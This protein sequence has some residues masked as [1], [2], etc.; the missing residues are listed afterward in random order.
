MSESCVNFKSPSLF[1]ITRSLTRPHHRKS[2]ANASH[3][4]AIGDSGTTHNLLRA[5]HV[6][7]LVVTPC[8]DL[9]V[10]LPNGAS[11]TSTH[12]GKLPLTSSQCS[13]PFY[14]FSDDDLQHSLLSFSA[15]CNEH[16]CVVT[17]TRTDVFIRQGTK[18]L[19]HGTK[20]VEDTLW[21]ID[22]DDFTSCP[23]LPS[24]LCNNA[25]KTDTDA[26][27][28]AFV[29]ASFGYPTLSTFINAIRMGWLSKYPRLTAA[30]V[31]ANPPHAIATA[32]GH[33]DQTRQ[34][35]KK[36]KP[37]PT[38]TPTNVPSAAPSEP[39]DDTPSDESDMCIKTYDFDDCYEPIHADLTARFP[40]ISRKGNQYLL[41]ACWHGYCHFELLPSRKSSSYIAAY[42]KVLAFFRGLGHTPAILRL[43]NETSDKLEAYLAEEKV[44][45]Q[46]VPPGSHRALKAER[47]IRTSKNHL[48]SMLCGTHSDF[49]LDLWDE[50]V[51]QAELT[52]AH[53]L[54]YTLD[55][56]KCAYD[57]MHPNQYD[58]AAH[59]IAPVGTLVVVHEKP[60]VRGSWAPHGAKGY[61][62]GPAVKHYHC[63]RTWILSTQ[64]ERITDTVEWFP[65]PLKLPGRSPHAMVTA[66]L[67]D[68][69]T[70]IRDFPASTLVP[71][72]KL[73]FHVTTA[74]DALRA[75]IDLFE[76]PSVLA[77]TPSVPVSDTSVPLKRVPTSTDHV[78]IQRVSA[79][80][81]N[82][83]TP[84]L[85][86]TPP[87][88]P[89]VAPTAMP[90]ADVNAS[91]AAAPRSTASRKRAP[92]RVIFIEPPPARTCR[93]PPV[94][95]VGTTA[96]R[97]VPS[98]HDSVRGDGLGRDID[99]SISQAPSIHTGSSVVPFERIDSA[100]VPATSQQ[101][102]HFSSG[103]PTVQSDVTQR[104]DTV[105]ETGTSISQAPSIHNSSSVV[106]VNSLASRNT[107]ANSQQKGHFSSG[108]SP[109]HGD[110]TQ[111]KSKSMPNSES[112]RELQLSPTE[113]ATASR[114]PSRRHRRPSFKV[115][116]NGDHKRK[117]RSISTAPSPY[118]ASDAA[119]A[120]AARAYGLSSN[121]DDDDSP[122]VCWALS[123]TLGQANAALNLNSDGSPLT[124]RSAINGPNGAH[125]RREEG[126][127]I[128]KL[129]DTNTMHAVHVFAQPA[130]RRK[131]TTYYNPQVKEKPGI[132][133][134]TGEDTTRRRV[135]GTIGG[136]RINYPGEVSAR[137]ADMEVVK[138]LLNSVV[139]TDAKWMTL[140][141]EDYYLGTPLPRHEWL[142]IHVKFIPSDTIAMYE[143][144]QYIINEHILFCV[145][146]GMYGLPQAGKLAQDRLCAHLASFG[147]VQAANV[148]CLF[149]HESN[150]VT[151]TLVVDDFGVK[152]HSRDAAEHLI[153]CL[154]DL[155]KLKVDWSGSTY[156]GITI[157]FDA[158]AHS[159]ALSMPGYI[160]KLLQRF[161]RRGKQ[162][163][164]KSPAV[165]VP[166]YP[167]SGPQYV[168]PDE[169]PPL[170]AS[171][172]TEVQE[173]V[174]CFLWYGRVIDSTFL[175]AVNAINSEMVDPTQRL[176]R[177]CERLL[178]YAASYPDNSL[179]YRASDMILE[180]QTDA[181][182]LSRSR[183]RSVVGGLGY[184]GS[185]GSAGIPN[186]AIFTHSAVLDV[187]VAS[188]GEAE[189]GAAFTI[190]QK[191]E[192]SRTILAAI[193][194]PQPATVLYC[195]NQCAIGL[196][197]DTVK[198]RRSKSVDMRYHWLRDRVRQD[199]FSVIW[200][201]GK[202]LLA[203]FFTKPLP[204]H[205]HELLMKSLVSIPIAAPG[206]FLNA[207]ARQAN[208]RRAQ[209]ACV[210]ATRRTRTA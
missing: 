166:W 148:P 11:I 64:S 146:K 135:R 132:H 15:L 39:I 67:R 61:Y 89:A 147:Y 206:H 47:N 51:Q 104:Q 29:H 205:R 152:Y 197:N 72:D 94:N 137:T 83:A 41:V 16:D 129:I 23:T 57:G 131:D 110:V 154:Q 118:S 124:Y 71:R 7:N 53:L 173:I 195:D 5:S 25:Y 9:H 126:V 14:V 35:K 138:I 167:R 86:V 209:A 81:S 95:P 127:E 78:N 79:T 66:A 96:K 120:S 198:Q 107:P 142:R 73:E 108:V 69:A 192:F 141:I 43:D 210:V 184:L 122:P 92:K 10:T 208:A 55:R 188:A 20:S 203:D 109:V 48:I 133:S 196:A 56:T 49:P 156:L 24:A 40:V 85:V 112:R 22:L 32:K 99:T 185:G 204:V 125:W 111:R 17:L 168:E 21:H 139:S 144:E 201:S 97:E 105:R 119:F 106:P 100:N 34:V 18:L 30:I 19:F 102:G 199:H 136:D 189:Y 151:F 77:D 88:A 36:G 101:N 181:S 162:S 4:S 140:D 93:G 177:D 183:S 62:L 157:A 1:N 145:T 158:A 45:M 159:V 130:D 163:Q 149:Q 13:T 68:L 123:R 37:H 165:Y 128:G 6:K 161:T 190:A 171:E 155:Y 182:Y 82:A 170:T 59:P 8:P 150:G 70:A 31:S 54:P 194:H 52:L 134:D 164:A 75:V 12:V 193:G 175:P 191:A 65:A 176:L 116:T 63:W 84:A 153:K 121:I 113:S 28:V 2:V 3:A 42:A 80:P 91:P 180:A 90:S 60:A 207:R 46:F 44:T 103:V 58:F 74:T 179:V 202:S 115:Q 186:G 87:H 114:P 178:A 143:L 172:V 200:L 27:F 33:L 38:N 160:Q 174:G 169:S 50:I 117:P 98:T 76:P 187:V 26:E